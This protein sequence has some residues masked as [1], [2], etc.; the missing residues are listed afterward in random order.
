MDEGKIT[1]PFVN[2]QDLITDL[3]SKHPRKHHRRALIKLISD[4]KA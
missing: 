1:I 3:G 2:T 4:F